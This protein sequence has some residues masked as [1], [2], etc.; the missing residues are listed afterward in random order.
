[1]EI[2]SKIPE[3]SVFETG[4]VESKELQHWSKILL[5]LSREM[6]VHDWEVEKEK[7]LDIHRIME[8]LRSNDRIATERANFEYLQKG[9][10]ES[11]D[12][13]QEPGGGNV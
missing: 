8:M 1:M 13:P 9:M 4:T 5:E 3:L 2:V 10:S 7:E 12:K 11:E 6:R